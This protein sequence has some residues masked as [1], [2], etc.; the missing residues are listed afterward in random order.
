ML[1]IIIIS[2]GLRSFDENTCICEVLFLSGIWMSV[3]LLPFLVMWALKRTCCLEEVVSLLAFLI[4]YFLVSLILTLPHGLRPWN[5]IHAYL[6]M[7][8]QD[9][10][11]QVWCH[12]NTK[13][14]S[15]V[16]QYSKFKYAHIKVAK[17]KQRLTFFSQFL[18][19]KTSVNKLQLYLENK[20]TYSIIS[21][22]FL[23]GC[24]HLTSMAS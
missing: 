1:L 12:F 20:I 2:P 23:Q 15:N 3:L 11:Y 4:P 7:T 10:S 16:P 24:A 9:E 18:N 14:G 21:E 5:Y 6:S 19:I 17:I 8:R 13:C 22:N